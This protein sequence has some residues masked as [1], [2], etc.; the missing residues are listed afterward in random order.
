MRG[1]CVQERKGG[2]ERKGENGRER[3]GEKGREGGRERE[4]GSERDGAREFTVEHVIHV[5]GMTHI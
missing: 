2:R 3:K 5:C 1:Q 4:K